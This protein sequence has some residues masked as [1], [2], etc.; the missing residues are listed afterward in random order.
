MKI[1]L[2]DLDFFL[3]SKRLPNI[4]LM[5]IT[6]YIDISMRR[7][8]STNCFPFTLKLKHNYIRANMLFNVSIVAHS[9][10]LQV[11][12]VIG[13]HLRILNQT[14]YLIYRYISLL[15]RFLKI[16]HISIHSFQSIRL[17]LDCPCLPLN[18]PSDRTCNCQ[19]TRY[20]LIKI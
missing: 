4:N 1:V 2:F 10:L 11:S 16:Y 3:T 20:V 18:Q 15:F 14:L 9:G 19:E 13:S 5:D 12:V 17:W 7:M 8:G 6:I